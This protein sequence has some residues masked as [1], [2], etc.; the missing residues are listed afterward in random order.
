MK[1]ALCARN[2]SPL[3]DHHDSA[4]PRPFY[5]KRIRTH[6]I[7]GSVSQFVS[8]QNGQSEIGRREGGGSSQDFIRDETG[9]VW[10]LANGGAG[11]GAEVCTWTLLTRQT[12]LSVR[13][14]LVGKVTY[15]ASS[16]GRGRLQGKSIN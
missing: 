13:V 14:V 8:W 1:L 16:A 7:C 5:L 10:I 3:L 6:S 9:L 15:G 4:Q 11:A 2:P 12:E